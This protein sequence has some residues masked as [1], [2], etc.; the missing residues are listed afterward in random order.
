MTK[1]DAAA[2][3]TRARDAFH[4]FVDHPAFSCLAARGVVNSGG[5]EV[6]A[7]GAM[8]SKRSTRSL[9]RNLGAFVDESDTDDH[10]LRSFV[11]VFSG[12]HFADELAFERDLWRQLQALHEHDPDADAWAPGVSDDPDDPQF[13]FSFRKTA[14]FVIGLHPNA[15]RIARRFQWP[16]L[17]FN[18]RAQFDNLRA[19]GRFEPLRGKVR[20]REI[21]LQ[22]S[23]N[24][25][26]ADFGERSEARQYSG[27]VAE[28]SWRCPFHRST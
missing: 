20:E 6:R 1:L 15:S 16:A 11:A 17:V 5:S 14:W 10:S 13:A 21:A 23:L 9:A 12:S 4:A 18:P 27:R 2:H 7:Y 25:N 22:G 3:H 28:D 26:L 19:T 24:P 8:G